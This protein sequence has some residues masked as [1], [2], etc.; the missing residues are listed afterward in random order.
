MA[1]SLDS[2]DIMSLDSGDATSDQMLKEISLI[3]SSGERVSIQRQALEMSDFART[4]LEGD[5][6]ASEIHLYHIDTLTVKLC[7]DYMTHHLVVAPRRIETP[8][9]TNQLVDLVSPWDAEFI[10]LQTQEQ[11]FKTLLA[12]NYMNIRPLLLLCSAAIACQLK[13]K[14]PSEIK[15]HFNIRSDATPQEEEEIRR[16]YK[17]LIN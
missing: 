4:T 1:M 9:L 2:G 6:T 14:T 11:I 15:S 7:C 5:D 12:A 10:Q 8:L 13:G 16:E 17:D 3:S